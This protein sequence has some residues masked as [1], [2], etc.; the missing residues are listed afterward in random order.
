LSQAPVIKAVAGVA[1]EDCIVLL[2]RIAEGPAPD[3][4]AAA[5]EAVEH[6][7]AERRLER[8]WQGRC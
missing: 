7:L 3:L 6:P 2:G 1:D 5:L 4:A 8:L